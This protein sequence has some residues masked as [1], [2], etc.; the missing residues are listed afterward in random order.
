M[1]YIVFVGLLFDPRGHIS[2]GISKHNDWVMCIESRRSH[3]IDLYDFPPAIY[4]AGV[5]LLAY[6]IP[7]YHISII[8]F[9]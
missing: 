5:I 2:F 7:F 8:Y 6:I 1:T 3:I 9:Y 4:E